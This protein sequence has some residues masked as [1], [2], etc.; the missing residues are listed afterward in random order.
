MTDPDPSLQQA[1]D[2]AHAARAEFQAALEGA[3][4]WFTPDR[5]KA[6]AAIAA[7]QQIDEAKAALRRSVTRHPLA[8]WSALALTATILTYVLR[9]PFAALTRVGKDSVHALR[10]R[11]VQRKNK[12]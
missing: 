8:T 12:Q 9:R 5:L 6:E 1:Q 4:N 3:L 7:T 2:R 10:N 11:F